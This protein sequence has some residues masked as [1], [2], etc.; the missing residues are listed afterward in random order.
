MATLSL[1]LMWFTVIV[2]KL[3]YTNFFFNMGVAIGLLLGS[4]IRLFLIDRKF[5]I[6]LHKDKD[7]IRITY[8]TNFLQEKEIIFKKESS[9]KLMVKKRNLIFYDFDR[10]ALGSTNS[11]TYF[12]LF[13][14][15]TK[16]QLSKEISNLEK[17]DS[18][19][20]E[21]ETLNS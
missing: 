3:I 11:L 17:M 12:H 7:V 1:P 20:S 6:G 15:K 9:L 16:T 18:S 2:I 21:F 13:D 10:L 5:L 14:K 19:S 8:L 4:A